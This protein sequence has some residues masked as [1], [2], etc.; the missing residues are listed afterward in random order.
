MEDAIRVNPASYLPNVNSATALT[1]MAKAVIAAN[2]INS[3]KA[4]PKRKPARVAPGVLVVSGAWAEMRGHGPERLFRDEV[5]FASAERSKGLVAGDNRKNFVVVPGASRF[6]GC[7]DLDEIHVVNQP[8]IGAKFAAFREDRSS[9][10]LL[11]TASASSVPAA[12]TARK[13]WSTEE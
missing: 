9:R 2:A 11:A 8:A 7:L 4:T 13:Q 3:R 5:A 1:A 6:L 10:I 12:R